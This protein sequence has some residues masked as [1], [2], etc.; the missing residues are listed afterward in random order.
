MINMNQFNH[1]FSYILQ[2]NSDS[3]YILNQSKFVDVELNAMNNQQLDQLIQQ[4]R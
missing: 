4:V 3:S 2:T 1:Q